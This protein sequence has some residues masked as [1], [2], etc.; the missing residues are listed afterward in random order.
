MQRAIGGGMA[1]FVV[2]FAHT[3]SKLHLMAR[4]RIHQGRLTHAGR[5]Q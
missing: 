2:L 4:E 1:A 5:S 3:L